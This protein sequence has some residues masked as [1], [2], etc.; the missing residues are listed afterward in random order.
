MH[1]AV[2]DMKYLT[3]FR[4]MFIISILGFPLFC[5]SAYADVDWNFSKAKKLAKDIYSGDETTFYCGCDYK[6]EGKK[7]IPVRKP[8]GY[9]P[10]NEFTKAGKVNSRSIRIEWEHVMPAWFFGNTMSCW[11]KGGRK[12]CK[13][14][15]NFEELLYFN[16]DKI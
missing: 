14:D 6:E 3:F 5:V 10:R 15:K 9:F 8:C 4:K 1:G 7:L 2:T 16:L 13:K 12:A 11:K